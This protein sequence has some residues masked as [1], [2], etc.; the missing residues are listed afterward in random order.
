MTDDELERALEQALDVEPQPDFLARV[1]TGLAQEPAPS[2]WAGW[3]RAAVAG[4]AAAGLIALVTLR[5]ADDSGGP[6]VADS[7]LAAPVARPMAQTTRA[8]EV[9]EPR[10]AQPSAAPAVRTARAAVRP[11][12][13]PAATAALADAEM[14]RLVIEAAQEGLFQPA[15]SLAGPLEVTRLELPPLALEPLAAIAPVDEGERP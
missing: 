7:P 11:R 2:P 14:L 1:R 4:S 6:A 5:P 9:E 10:V 8:S 15:D 12:R 13:T 3:W